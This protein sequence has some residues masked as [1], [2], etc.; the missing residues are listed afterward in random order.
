MKRVHR[1]ERWKRPSE[2]VAVPARAPRKART[3]LPPPLTV[4]PA[5]EARVLGDMT[6]LVSAGAQTLPSCDLLEALAQHGPVSSG[7]RET[8]HRFKRGTLVVLH[9]GRSREVLLLTA[10][11]LRAMRGSLDTRRRSG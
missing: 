7:A 6:V 5:F 1:W 4:R 3:P 2:R 11:E 9:T 8:K 10:T